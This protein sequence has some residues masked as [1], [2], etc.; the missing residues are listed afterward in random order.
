MSGA[1]DMKWTARDYA[2]VLAILREPRAELR[3]TPADIPEERVAAARGS[4]SANS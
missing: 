3:E 2:L 1:Y 4:S